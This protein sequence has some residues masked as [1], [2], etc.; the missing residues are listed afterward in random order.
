METWVIHGSA[1]LVFPRPIAGSKHPHGSIPILIPAPSGHHL[2]PDPGSIPISAPSRHHPSSIPTPAS[3][4]AHLHPIPAPSKDRLR[5][6]PPRGC[7]APGRTRHLPGIPSPTTSRASPRAPSIS[8]DTQHLSQGTQH[9]LR[10][11]TTHSISQGCS[12][13][14]NDSQ[15]PAMVFPQ[16]PSPCPSDQLRYLV[17]LDVPVLA[18]G[19]WRFPGDVQLGGRGRLYCHVLGSA[20]GHWADGGDSVTALLGPGRENHTPDVGD[21]LPWFDV[22]YQGP[23]SR[24]GCA[25]RLTRFAHEDL[26]G[27]AGGALAHRIVHAHADLVA[28]V[29]AQVWVG[30][31]GRRGERSHPC[32]QWWGGP[33][34]PAPSPGSSPR[35]NGS[36]Q[37]EGSPGHP[38]V[39]PTAWAGGEQWGGTQGGREGWGGDLLSSSYWVRETSLRLCTV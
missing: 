36:G 25:K 2:H 17:A 18:L 16:E 8:Y 1:H 6:L 20:S 21:A 22:G 5:H 34:G 13:P 39:H 23:L 38:T 14:P 33:R 30:G 27:G 15:H 7:S 3:F 31:K 10:S 11:T 12:A 37:A 19:G 4:Q 26:L 24:Q 29:L 32:G 35:G 28:P 9:L